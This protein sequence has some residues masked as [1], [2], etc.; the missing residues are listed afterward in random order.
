MTFWVYGVVVV[1]TRVLI[2]GGG[3][4]WHVGNFTQNNFSYG[5]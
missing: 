2:L 1:G 4:F 3:V 5:L